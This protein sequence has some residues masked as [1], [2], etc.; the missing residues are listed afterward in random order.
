LCQRVMGGRQTRYIWPTGKSVRNGSFGMSANEMRHFKKEK[1]HEK[2]EG[3]QIKQ[4]LVQRKE[5]KSRT[6]TVQKGEGIQIK[7]YNVRRE[8][9]K[10]VRYKGRSKAS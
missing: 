2:T 6:R 9:Q 5:E 3:I 8:N 7:Q 10:H 1:R 4:Y